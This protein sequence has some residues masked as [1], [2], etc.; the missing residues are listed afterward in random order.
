MGGVSGGAGG[1]QRMRPRK[2][3]AEFLR[4]KPAGGPKKG[5]QGGG[6]PKP[7]LGPQG[8]LGAPRGPLGAPRGPLGAPGDPGFVSL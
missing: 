6:V 8:P 2:T 1:P 4:M 3:K 5:V 7:A